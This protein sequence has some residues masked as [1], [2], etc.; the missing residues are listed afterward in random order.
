MQVSV[1]CSSFLTRISSRSY[2]CRSSLS[3]DTNHCSLDDYSESLSSLSDAE[4]ELDVTEIFGEDRFDQDDENDADYDDGAEQPETRRAC[5]TQSRSRGNE[6]PTSELMPFDT[7]CSATPTTAAAPAPT[8]PNYTVATPSSP[9]Q[10]PGKHLHAST[11]HYQQQQ[12]LIEELEAEQKHLQHAC[13]RQEK[14]LRS[15][16]RAR[17]AA[18]R[19][20]LHAQ[21]EIELL[22]EGICGALN[23][24]L[25]L[26]EAVELLRRQLQAAE[27]QAE[28]LGQDNAALRRELNDVVEGFRAERAGLQRRLDAV[29]GEKARRGRRASTAVQK[30]A[31][32]AV[33][34]STV[35]ATATATATPGAPAA[36]ASA[37]CGSSI[38][39]AG[40]ARKRQR[41]FTEE[42]AK[43]MRTLQSFFVRNG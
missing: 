15:S 32:A 7:V 43:G 27:L 40:P 31:S 42:D 39:G 23:E 26:N 11:T 17:Q 14:A 12:Q 35:T 41:R 20:A 28:A 3:T 5:R 8:R 2:P 4:S 1:P 10:C 33:T 30:K 18:E 9:Q 38:S 6:L 29:G 19:K 37:R 16:W 24:A 25:A 13:R 34:A 21:G 36:A 22:N